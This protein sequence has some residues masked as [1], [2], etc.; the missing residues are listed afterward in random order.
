MNKSRKMEPNKN[1]TFLKVKS[2]KPAAES[3]EPGSFADRELLKKWISEFE[4]AL[5][6]INRGL[7]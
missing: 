2:S 4:R 7:L 5:K 6:M 1:R 3:N